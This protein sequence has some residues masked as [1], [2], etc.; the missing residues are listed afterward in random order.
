MVMAESKDKPWIDG[1]TMLYLN[2]YKDF[3]KNKAALLKHNA[4]VI[5]LNVFMNQ[6]YNW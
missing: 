1:M 3:N 6:G 5:C 4:A 2:G